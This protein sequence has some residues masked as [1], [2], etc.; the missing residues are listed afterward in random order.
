[1]MLDFVVFVSRLSDAI[2]IVYVFLQEI[3]PRP[4]THCQ[5]GLTGTGE[6]VRL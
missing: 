2:Y 1:M 6:K 5:V 4:A 3:V